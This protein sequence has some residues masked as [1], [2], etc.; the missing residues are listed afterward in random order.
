M[1]KKM[2]FV[3]SK[4]HS[5]NR[6]TADRKISDEAYDRLWAGQ[7]NCAYWHGVFGGL[8]L[9][10]LRSAIY[11]HLIEAEKIIDKDTA[12]IHKLD[13]DI[14]GRDELLLENSKLNLYFDPNDGGSLFELDY[15][16]LSVN[17]TN[18][19]T[20]REEAY[21]KKIREKIKKHTVDVQGPES[22]HDLVLAKEEGLDKYLVYDTYKRNSLIEHFLRDDI[23]AENFSRNR[24][25]ELGD[26]A[27]NVY[28]G[29]SKKE[30]NAISVTLKKE[31]QVRLGEFKNT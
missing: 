17:L 20:R 22:I 4:V 3:S 14:D 12:D 13:F 28:T 11:N 15:K 30:K 24:Y 2:L 26:F 21:H 8:Y 25:E 7:C 18:V 10:H 29:A 16:P 6:E 1:H 31:G 5:I 27:T 19:L 9:N 23:S